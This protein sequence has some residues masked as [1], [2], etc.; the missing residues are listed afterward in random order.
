MIET[1]KLT[2]GSGARGKRPPPK[3]PA[4]APLLDLIDRPQPVPDSEKSE[5]RLRF[6]KFDRENPKMFAL[7]ERFTM[8]AIRSGRKK[9]GARLI[10]ERIRW[11]IYVLTTTDDGFKMNGNYVPFFAR[12]FIAAHPQHA[13][14]FELRSSVADAP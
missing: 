7:F 8:E 11:E 1:L 13:K 2:K 9:I 3:E 12:K 6:E 10:V 14:I 4:T 5:A